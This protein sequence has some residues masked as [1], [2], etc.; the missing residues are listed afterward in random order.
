MA[1]AEGIVFTGLSDSGK[2]ALPMKRYIRLAGESGQSCSE[3]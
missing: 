2:Y 3:G 1:V